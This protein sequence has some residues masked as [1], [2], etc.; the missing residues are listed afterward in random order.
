VVQSI[1]T[2]TQSL[3]II[4]SVHDGW[5]RIKIPTANLGT[6]SNGSI[7]GLIAIVKISKAKTNYDVGERL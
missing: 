7:S 6:F 4:G 1:V 5:Y 3:R 2:L